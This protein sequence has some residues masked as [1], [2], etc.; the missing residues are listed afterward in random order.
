MFLSIIFGIL[1]IVAVL[2]LINRFR[3]RGELNNRSHQKRR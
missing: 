2:Y 3:K 1:F